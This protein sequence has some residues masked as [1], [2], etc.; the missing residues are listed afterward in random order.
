MHRGQGLG[1][2]RRSRPSIHPPL[3]ELLWIKRRSF[4]VRHARRRLPAESALISAARGNADSFC[5]ARAFPSLLLHKVAGE[6]WLPKTAIWLV[7]QY[8]FHVRSLGFLKCA[9]VDTV[10]DRNDEARHHE[11]TNHHFHRYWFPLFHATLTSKFVPRSDVQLAPPREETQAR[12][13]GL[14]IFQGAC[15]RCHAFNGTGVNDPRAALLRAPSVND[16]AC[17][18]LMQ[19]LLHGSQLKTDQFEAVM[20]GF[21]AY[22]NQELA[23]VANYVLDHFDG[24]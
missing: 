6:I 10:D 5:S 2:E 13:L 18:N 22:R 7:T 12:S 19:V 23:A 1:S 14:D 11:A 21:E 24:K 8:L 17:I 9:P 3:R 15:A 4:E 20:A 16:S